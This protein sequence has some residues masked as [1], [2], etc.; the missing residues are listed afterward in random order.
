[1]TR[2]HSLVKDEG[3]DWA[4]VALWGGLEIKRHMKSDR[5]REEDDE[6]DRV[7]RHPICI[8]E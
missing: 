3:A 2:H 7:H 4:L 8:S 1:M 6:S 5:E